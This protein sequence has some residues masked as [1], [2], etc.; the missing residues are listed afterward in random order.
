MIL[1]KKQIT[2][3]LQSIPSEK[4]SQCTPVQ[5]EIRAR[6]KDELTK[7]T[8]MEDAGDDLFMQFMK[9][10]G[11]FSTKDYKFRYLADTNG[12]AI[13]RRSTEKICATAFDNKIHTLNR[14]NE[15]PHIPRFMTCC[16]CGMPIQEGYVSNKKDKSKCKCEYCFSTQMNTTYGHGKWEYTDKIITGDDGNDA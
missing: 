2:G 15:T 3:L 5:M 7:I 13:V 10:V 8:E 4:S 6:L 16:S 11:N 9:R 12:V 1:T 14:E